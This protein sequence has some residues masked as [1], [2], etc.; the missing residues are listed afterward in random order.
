MA[1]IANLFLLICA[2]WEEAD[3]TG[4]NQTDQASHASELLGLEEVTLVAAGAIELI[5]TVALVDDDGR[6]GLRSRWLHIHRLLHNHRL[7]HHH[8]WLLYH[9]GLHVHLWV[10]IC[11]KF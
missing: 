8:N 7:L 10:S 5:V 11:L 9:N 6:A 4:A 3:S 1:V 2:V